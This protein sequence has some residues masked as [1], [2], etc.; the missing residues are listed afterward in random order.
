MQGIQ[1]HTLTDEELLHYADLMGAEELTSE[2]VGE[3]VKRAF[4]GWTAVPADVVDPR[5]L[6][7]F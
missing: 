4:S 3:I 5:Q 2:W 1:P 6:Q 7:L